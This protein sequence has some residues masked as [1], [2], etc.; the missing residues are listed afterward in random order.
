M[1]IY[2]EEGECGKISNEGWGVTQNYCVILH[3]GMVR[4]CQSYLE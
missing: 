3:E 2:E 1:N 4:F